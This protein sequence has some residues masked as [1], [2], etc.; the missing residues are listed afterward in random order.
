MHVKYSTRLT[1]AVV[2]GSLFWLGILLDADDGRLPDPRAG[3]RSGDNLVAGGLVA[4]A[5]SS[6][7]RC[8][9]AVA[10]LPAAPAESVPWNLDR[11][12][13]R[14]LPLDGRFAHEGD[15]AGVHAYRDRHRHSEEPSRVRRARRL[16][17]RLHAPEI[18]AARSRTTAI[19]PDL[20][21]G[22]ARMSRASS[23]AGRSASAPGVRL[24]ALRI[25][26]CTGTT[27]TDFAAAV[28][29]VDWITAHGRHPGI[30]NISPARWQTADTALDDAVRRSIAAGF[31]YVLSAGGV[32]NVTAFSPQRVSEAVV[33]GSTSRTDAPA[34][35]GYGP[36]LTLFAPGIRIPGAGNLGDTATFVGRRGFVR[37]AARRR[38][39]RDLSSTPSNC[40]CG[41]GKAGDRRRCHTRRR[42]E[43]WASAESTSSHDR[44]LIP[45][46]P[47]SWPLIQGILSRVHGTIRHR[48]NGRDAR[49][50]AR[51][52]PRRDSRRRSEP[53]DHSA[54]TGDTSRCSA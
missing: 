32:D 49:S 17:R 22:T 35:S 3:R 29:A 28:R 19:V 50:N 6:S 4:G 45:G 51:V 10:A 11:I 14:A 41:R 53:S 16:D 20:R 37:G 39:R 46:A 15:G 36:G 30:V 38:R 5:R 12:D 43:S 31:L 24:H 2:L 40:H 44:P 42:R 34:T 33:V 21:K 47:H 25:L 7:V 26:P 27:R 54:T 1:W 13:Q 52:H 9:F 48:R 18:L 23:A 8:V